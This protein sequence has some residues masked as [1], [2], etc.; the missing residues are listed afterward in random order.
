VALVD[1]VDL[2]LTLVR[3]PAQ[4]ELDAQGFLVNRLQQSR[5]QVTVDLDRRPDDLLRQFITHVFS[6]FLCVLCDLCG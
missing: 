1:H 6:L 3:N 5:P 2:D 4:V